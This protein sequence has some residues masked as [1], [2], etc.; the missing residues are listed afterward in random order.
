MVRKEIVECLRRGGVGVLPTDTI[1]GLVGSALKPATVARIY[2]LRKRKKNKPFIVLIAS[3]ADVRRFGVRPTA[4][5]WTVLRKL[6]PGPVSI[7]LPV[8]GTEFRYLHGE[9]GIAFRVP[10]PAWLRALLQQTGP[11]AAPSANIAGKP[12][13]ETVREAFEAFGGKVDFYLDRGR[14]TGAPST[15]IE[16]KR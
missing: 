1:Y 13:A 12:A 6:W 8:T 4:R 7:V 14:R 16:I 3:P 11:L 15:L 9:N 5:N 10:K 2:A